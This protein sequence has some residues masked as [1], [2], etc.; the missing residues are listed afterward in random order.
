MDFFYFF[1]GELSLRRTVPRRT[2]LEPYLQ[3]CYQDDNDYPKHVT[4]AYKITYKRFTIMIMTIKHVTLDI[5]NYLQTF[6]QGDNA[7]PKHVAALGV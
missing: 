6:Y 7:H 5:Y 4:L 2:V 3:T 1:Y